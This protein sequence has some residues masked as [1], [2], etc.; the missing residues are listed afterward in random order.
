MRFASTS[1]HALKERTSIEITMK[2]G[3]AY[4]RWGKPDEAARF[5]DR[6]LKAFDQRVAKG[7]DDPY[8]RYY[9]ACLLAMRG[10]IDRAL[11]MIERVH[12]ALPALTTAR[13]RRD[14]DLENL[15]GHP[16]FDALQRT[17]S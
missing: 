2:L 6:A 8:T 16:R 7:G 12:R 5:F 14:P 4:Y 9:I 17:A 3:A 10:E 15:K 1:D 11:D 13:I